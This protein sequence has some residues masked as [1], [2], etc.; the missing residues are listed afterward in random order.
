MTSTTSLTSLGPAAPSVARRTS[1]TARSPHLAIRNVAV[2][3][4]RTDDAD[5]ARKLG[6]NVL[7][8]LSSVLLSTLAVSRYVSLRHTDHYIT[9][10]TEEYAYTMLLLLPSRHTPFPSIPHA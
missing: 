9:S 3:S 7:M 1:T 6:R 4:A 8:G 10:Y 5:G 2:A